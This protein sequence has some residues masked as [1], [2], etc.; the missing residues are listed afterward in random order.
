MA[1][2]EYG[3]RDLRNNTAAVLAAVEHGDQ[4]F[5]TNRGRRVAELRPITHEGSIDRLLDLADEISP[6][7]T[8]AFDD[9]QQSKL[10]DIEAQARGVDSW[11]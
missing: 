11:R 6:G 1:T 8:G 7:D 2:R 10:D 5:L 9:L 4:V 3:V